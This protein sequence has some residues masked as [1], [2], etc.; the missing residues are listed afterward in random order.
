MR[1]EKTDRRLPPPTEEGHLSSSSL[2][3]GGGNMAVSY[4]DLFQYTIV[5]LT[6]AALLIASRK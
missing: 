1:I 4:S 3:Q 6:L 5:L 2:A